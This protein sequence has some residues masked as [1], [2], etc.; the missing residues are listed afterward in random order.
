M[1]N[2]GAETALLRRFRSTA[3]TICIVHRGFFAHIG[4][5]S[6]VSKSRHTKYSFDGATMVNARTVPSLSINTYADIAL[7]RGHRQ[8]DRTENDEY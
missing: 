2:F 3:G 7:D 1:L 5:I 8:G 4:R 6:P